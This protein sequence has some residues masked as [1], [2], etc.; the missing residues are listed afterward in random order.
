LFV[1][2]EVGHDGFEEEIRLAR[3]DM[4]LDYAGYLR[5]RVLD[6]A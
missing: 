3:D 1:R 6:E 5:D 2:R 4:A